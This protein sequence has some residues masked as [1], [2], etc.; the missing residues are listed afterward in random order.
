MPILLGLHLPLKRRI[1]LVCVFSIAL[2][3]TETDI[4]IIVGCM[5]ACAQFLSPGASAS[6]FF[7]SLRSRLLGSRRAG[8]GTGKTTSSK[9][10]LSYE[11]QQ[12]QQKRGQFG[13]GSDESKQI[14]DYEMTD[15]QSLKATARVDDG[16]DWHRQSNHLREDRSAQQWV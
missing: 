5:P 14:L 13:G 8:T 11:Q 4:A 2:L 10:S 1:Q 3:L 6:T 9:L 16:L 12:Q 15:T 7:R